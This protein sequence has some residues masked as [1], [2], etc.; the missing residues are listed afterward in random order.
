MQSRKRVEP[1]PG[2]RGRARGKTAAS[3]KRELA[4]RARTSTRLAKTAHIVP[5]CCSSFPAGLNKSSYSSDTPFFV[6]APLSRHGI[7]PAAVG[8]RSTC[9]SHV[10]NGTGTRTR[11]RT[12]SGGNGNGHITQDERMNEVNPIYASGGGA[13]PN[14]T[15]MLHSIGAQYGVD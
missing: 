2:D 4:T 8:V 13:S 5:S 11:T 9:G 6:L 12:R 15:G 3:Q 10:M 14:E 7:P 1:R